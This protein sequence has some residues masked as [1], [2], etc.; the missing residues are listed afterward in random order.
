MSFPTLKLSLSLNPS[1]RDAAA[2]PPPPL[3]PPPEPP[4]GGGALWSVVGDGTLTVGVD[5]G[6]G[7]LDGHDSD[8]LAAGAGRLSEERGAPGGSWKVRTWPVSSFTVTV[9]SELEATE[10]VGSAATPA[11]A[12]KMPSVTSATF[13]FPRPNTVAFS[14]P[15]G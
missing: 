7:G 1:P 9:Q 8:M 15:D 10:A 6:G 3:P 14:P 13:S 2:M 12:N 4:L 11:T 5:T